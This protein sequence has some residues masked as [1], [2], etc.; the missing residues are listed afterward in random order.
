M[1]RIP[2]ASGVTFTDAQLHLI[3]SIL[4]SW[5]G[6][7]SIDIRLSVP[8]WRRVY[9]VLLMGPERRDADR[10]EEE[11]KTHPLLVL[12]N[13]I[14]VLTFVGV[15]ALLIGLYNAALIKFFWEIYSFILVLFH[16]IINI[17]RGG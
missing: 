16:D 12:G 15:L 11:R 3:K 14:F 17:F 9:L 4:G 2:P 1:A 5:S 13:V 7:H 8:L 6:R 10:R